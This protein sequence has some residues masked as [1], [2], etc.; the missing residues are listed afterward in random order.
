MFEQEFELIRK[1]VSEVNNRMEQIVNLLTKFVPPSQL[2]TLPHLPSI[3]KKEYKKEDN[4]I[5]LRYRYNYF[6]NGLVESCT[7]ISN[8]T[9]LETSPDIGSP[10][11]FYNNEKGFITLKRWKKEGK[12]CRDGDLPT[13]EEYYNNGNIKCKRWLNSDSNLHRLENKPALIK[14][15]KE[16]KETELHFKRDGLYY[17][18]HHW[19]VI[20]Y[21]NNP[22]EYAYKKV[23]YLPKTNVNK[24]VIYYEKYNHLHKVIKR[25]RYYNTTDKL[26]SVE[27]FDPTG[28]YKIKERWY[29]FTVSAYHVLHRPM[30]DGP[31]ITI[32]YKNKPFIESFYEE[33]IL[34]DTKYHDIND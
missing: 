13:E 29:K 32:Y 17:E 20:S 5:K 19:D 21:N 10:S 33:G 11:S 25:V 18:G 23:K 31:A 12:Y 8:L 9:D 2:P 15:N 1:E 34:K 24:D 22:E 16:G 26:P 7:I 4:K 30:E 6:P 3:D 27:K 28:T 14:Y